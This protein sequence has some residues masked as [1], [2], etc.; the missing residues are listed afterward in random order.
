M[1]RRTFLKTTTCALGAAYT[2]KA[3]AE[4]AESQEEPKQFKSGEKPNIVFIL[5]DQHNAK[6]MGHQ[7]HPDVK[8]PNLDLMSK[9]GVRFDA[10]ITNNPICTPS[11]VSF[12]SG[13][14]CHNHGY[15]ALGGPNPKGL[16]TVLGHFRRVGYKT[17]AT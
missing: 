3:M 14:Y 2:A 7:G 8:T 13:Q 11:R 16:P 5:S 15:Y 1:N 9:E 17:A 12:L 4:T 6:I 10:C